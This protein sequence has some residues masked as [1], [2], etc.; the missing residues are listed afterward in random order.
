MHLQ[1]VAIHGFGSLRDRVLGQL[2]RGVTIL[3]S[4]SAE[5]RRDFV[6]FVRNMFSRRGADVHAGLW[7]GGSA[8]VDSAGEIELQSGVT[9]SL[10]DGSGAELLPGWVDEAVFREICT[11]GLTESGRFE[12]LLSLCRESDQYLTLASERRQ[13]EQGLD[14]VRSERDGNGLSGGLVHRISELRRQQGELQGR[15]AALRRPSE[16]LAVRIRE[17]EQHRAET[18]QQ[19]SLAE[20]EESRLRD[21]VAQLEAALRFRAGRNS[22]ATAAETAESLGQWKAITALMA[23]E[24]SVCRRQESGQLAGEALQLLQ[25]DAWAAGER[26]F[27]QRAAAMQVCLQQAAAVVDLL[28]AELGTLT[29]SAAEQRLTDDSLRSL[30]DTELQAGLAAVQAERDAA[31]KEVER[32]VAVAA[33]TGSSLERL[34]SELQPALTLETLDQLRASIAELEAET[35]QLEEQRKRLNQAEETL[36]ELLARFSDRPVSSLL[37]TAGAALRT[38]TGGEVRGLQWDADGGLLV[39]MTGQSLP[40]SLATLDAAVQDL[41]G[42]VLRLSLLQLRA[43]SGSSVPVILDGVYLHADDAWSAGTATMLESFA[44]GG[45]QILVLTE[46]CDLSDRQGRWLDVRAF[47]QAAVVMADQS[48]ADQSVVEQPV[49]ESLLTVAQSAAPASEERPEAQSDAAEQQPVAVVSVP[50]VVPV[51]EK[52]AA[53]SS[54]PPLQLHV[55][56]EAEAVAE[57]PHAS[58]WL[59]YLEADHGV[60]DLAGISLGELEALRTAGVLTVRELL[61]QTIPQLEEKIRLKGFVVPVERLQA[62]WG[63]AE[64]ASR[65]PLLRRGDAALL[66]AAGIHSAEEL[67]RLRPETVYERVTRFQRSDAGARYRRAGR[68]IDRQQALNWARFGQFLRSLDDVYST[69][70]RFGAKTASKPTVR[71]VARGSAGS[72]V[73]STA[74]AESSRGAG[75]AES[76]AE[77]IPAVAVTKKRRRRVAADSGVASRR[78]KR[79]ARREQLTGEH[80]VDQAEAD[81][82]QLI[83]ERVGG[84]RFFLSRTSSVAAAP[85]IGPRTAELLQA[86]GLRTVEEFLSMT[87]E[88][89]AEKLH[90]PRITATIVRRWQS[91]ARL[92]CQIPELR[93]V[94]AQILVACGIVTP[95]ALSERGPEQVLLSVQPL[96]ESAEGQKLLKSAGQP[97]LATVTAWI[98]WAANARPFRAA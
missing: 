18:V 76:A 54:P 80:R 48:V 95:E 91:Q 88:R 58:N 30:A 34:R 41:T 38:V 31:A 94:D 21:R 97:D 84:M 40:V 25:S 27:S 28:Q 53:V 79:T 50:E 20:A 26:I 35:A 51:A 78:A 66:F 49:T 44:A 70:S 63:Q 8:A 57:D 11:P 56:E 61:L 47:P 89:V 29:E 1:S 85:S 72:R 24:L 10:A 98:Q 46:S 82:G 16:S 68:L 12:R 36:K 17:L 55:G 64:L 65:V 60:D 86:A 71:A 45:Q 7:H 77:E 22:G 19:L 87:P 3:H 90:S 39:A 74:A 14:R 5:E 93:S 83:A 75:T 69:R 81:G 43:Q 13:A 62:L 67:S 2:S 52:N 33:T 73:R 23:R 92:M 15:I 9:L 32:L 42:L 96:A 4:A 37:E 59:F 6:E